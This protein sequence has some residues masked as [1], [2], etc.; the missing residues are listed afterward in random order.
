MQDLQQNSIYSDAGYPNQFGPSGKFVE[1][2][3]KVTC[4]EIS[5]YRIQYSTALWLLEAPVRR[6]R[7]V[8][9]QVYIVY[10]NSRISNCQCS[11]FSKKFQ[12]SGFSAYP[13]GSPSQLIRISGVL[14]YLNSTERNVEFVC[15]FSG[16][17]DKLFQIVF[18][19][20]PSR[21]KSINYRFPCCVCNNS[22]CLSLPVVW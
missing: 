7:Q 6:G 3:I 20:S 14:L 15:A 13:D 19:V 1:N 8:Y 2:S 22:C 21:Y 11:I 16:Y 17:S 18:I 9:I 5:I 10:S 4:L 12:L